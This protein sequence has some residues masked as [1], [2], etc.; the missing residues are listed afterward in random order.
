MPTGSRSRRSSSAAKRRLRNLSDVPTEELQRQLAEM[1]A[2]LNL[3]LEEIPE[4]TG[5]NPTH[6]RLART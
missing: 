5:A 3:N 4:K 2:R 1:R 6:P